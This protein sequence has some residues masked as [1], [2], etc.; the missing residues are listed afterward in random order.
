LTADEPFKVI[1][2]GE[3]VVELLSFNN[4]PAAPLK[5]SVPPEAIVCVEPEAKV[6]V[7]AVVTDLVKL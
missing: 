7:S 6:R 5:V 3:F 4:W 1:L 2:Y